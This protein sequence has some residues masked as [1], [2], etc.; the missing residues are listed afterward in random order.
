MEKEL[1]RT[2]KSITDSWTLPEIEDFD[3]DTLLADIIVKGGQF[4]CLYQDPNYFHMMYL[5]HRPSAGVSR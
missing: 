2:Q 4:G 5:R 1:N 3:K